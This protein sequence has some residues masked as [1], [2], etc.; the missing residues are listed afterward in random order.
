MIGHITYLSRR[1]DAARSSAGA[2]ATSTK[3]GYDF[4]ADFEVESYL[5]YQGQSFTNRFDANTYLYITQGDR[6][7][8][9]GTAARAA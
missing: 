2:C 1:V 6:L 3:Y 4:A 9:P 8:R 5:R 7:L